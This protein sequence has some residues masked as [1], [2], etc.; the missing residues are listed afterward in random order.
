MENC[1]SEDEQHL[2]SLEGKALR[3]IRDCVRGVVTGW[4][5]GV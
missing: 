3:I 2:G 4:P 1:R 5:P